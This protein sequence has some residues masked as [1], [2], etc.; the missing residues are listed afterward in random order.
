M[1]RCGTVEHENGLRLG[2]AAVGNL[3]RIAAR[4]FKKDG[5]LRG[6]GPQREPGLGL[7]GAQGDQD[8]DSGKDQDPWAV[9]QNFTPYFESGTTEQPA[10]VDRA[11]YGRK[12]LRVNRPWVAVRKVGNL[13]ARERL[14]PQPS[15]ERHVHSLVQ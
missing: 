2:Y 12:A 14:S 4:P 6:I 7:R 15:L 1:P 9:W 3:E 5:V 8:Q 11:F 13:H 10:F